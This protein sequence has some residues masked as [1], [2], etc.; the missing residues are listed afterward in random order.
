[1]TLK[2]WLEK[3]YASADSPPEDDGGVNGALHQDRALTGSALFYIVFI[4]FSAFMLLK[5]FVG[6]IVGTFINTI[7]FTVLKPI[8]QTICSSV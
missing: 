5:L 1:M 2:G 8:L 3:L 7:K 6:T 4:W